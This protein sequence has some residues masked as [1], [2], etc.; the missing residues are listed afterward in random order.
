MDA[1][2]QETL[3]A[4]RFALDPTRRQTAD[5]ARHAGAARWAYNHAVALK[6]TAHRARRKRI[7]E[8][9]AA[10]STETQ[11][12]AVLA[13]E[14]KE[15]QARAKALQAEKTSLRAESKTAGGDAA[16]ELRARVTEL[17]DEQNALLAERIRTG[18]TIPS[19]FDTAALW[20]TTRDLPKEDG[21]SPWHPEV[22]TYAITSGFDNAQRAWKNF[23]D[24]RSGKR[25][26]ALVGYPAF[27]KKGRARDSFTLYHNVAKP[28]IRPEQRRRPWDHKKSDRTVVAGYRRLTLPTLGSIRLH[29]SAKT[30]VRALRAGRAQVQSVTVSRAGDRWYAAVLCKVRQDIPAKPTRRQTAAGAVA[31]KWDTSAITLHCHDRFETTAQPRY[32]HD[33]LKRLAHI[34][35]Q[36]S[37]KTKGSANRAKANART[38][39]LHHRVAEQRK[40]WLH[41]LTARLTTGY[42][43]VALEDLDVQNMI[44]ARPGGATRHRNRAILD[45]APGEMRRQITYKTSWNGSRLTLTERG[46]PTTRTCSACG[47]QNPRPTPPKQEF[48]CTTCGIT[49]PRSHNAAAVITRNA[50]PATPTDTPTKPDVAP[51]RG[52][53]QNAR[54]VTDH[55]RGR[56]DTM[57]REDPQAGTR[58]PQDGPPP[59]SNPGT[60][61]IPRQAEQTTEQT[62][63]GN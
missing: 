23:T 55:P 15:H 37:K 44:D 54:G 42:E 58:R 10:G 2:P 46:L 33:N 35:R 17:K 6:I 16:Q 21:G 62:D 39:R 45:T 25:K 57:N 53:T 36:A 19:A 13:A 24:S 27:H 20:R 56:P 22:N 31:V 12:R 60:F 3:R 11:A 52:E 26:G 63:R 29:D 43:V 5:L 8:L 61:H 51:D 32:L 1:Q 38:A 28:S 4:Y 59:G 47:R 48:H 50:T 41:Q 14:D 49:M 9:V 18:T 30:L 40:G 34:Q 7:A